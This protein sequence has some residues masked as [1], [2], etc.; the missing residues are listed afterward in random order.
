[1]IT[2]ERY[3]SPKVD[4]FKTTGEFVGVINNEHEFNKVRIQMLK[5]QVTNEYYFMW[6]EIKITVNEQGDMSRFPLGLYDQLQR[7]MA[8]TFR[9]VKQ[10]KKERE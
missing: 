7:D 5:E 2:I 8:E 1:M 4:M 10:N 9:I 6:N 3:E